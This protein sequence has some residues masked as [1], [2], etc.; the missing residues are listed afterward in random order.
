MASATNLTAWDN[1]L[2]QYYQDRPVI[3][4]VYKNHPFLTLVNK[5]PRFRGKNMPIRSSLEDLKV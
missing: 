4:T 5:N 2:K 1:S 3:D